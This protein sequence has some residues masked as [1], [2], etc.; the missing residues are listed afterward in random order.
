MTS[1]SKSR[2]LSLVYFPFT[3]I[4]LSLVQVL[5]SYFGRVILYRPVGS[6][7][8]KDLEPWMT[9][10]LFDI[11]V[12][13]EDAIDK[14]AL[15][16]EV[17]QWRRWALLNQGADTAYLKTTGLQIAPVHP[18]TPKIA[19]EIKGADHQTGENTKERHLTRQLF[20]RLAQDFDR[21]SMEL[22]EKLKGFKA[23][24]DTLQAFL[25]MDQPEEREDFMPA[26]PFRES[27]EDL[28]GFMIEHRMLAWNDLVQADP[29]AS[30]LL[31][32]DSPAAHAWFLDLAPA[33]IPLL[34]FDLPYTQPPGHGLPWKD[35][36]ENLFQTVL[37]NPWNEPLQQR[38]DARAREIEAIIS[39][40]SESVTKPGEKTASFHWHVVPN[41][42]AGNVL[43]QQ[44]ASG[45]S[46][47]VP[48]GENTLVGLVELAV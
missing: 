16:A 47:A 3:V 23:Q 17:E 7:P 37:T 28:G 38:I 21:L 25:R 39:S 18:L 45:D 34:E 9:Q 10:G 33:K 32:T 15:T 13:F 12:P 30:N 29:Q 6:A 41:Q 4:A 1:E 11:R 27:H 26:E 48:R 31:F 2:S 36:L 40:W 42:T 19:S 44:R 46:E 14:K 24:Q 20:L 43:K 35:P 5:S 22:G 8:M